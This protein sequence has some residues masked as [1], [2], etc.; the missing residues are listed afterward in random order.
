MSH[1]SPLPGS[2]SWGPATQVWGSE[3]WRWRVSRWIDEALSQRGVTR[4]PTSP[5]Q[6]RLRPWSTQLVVE[7]DRG[8]AWFK[9]TLPEG[10]PEVA[11]LRLLSEVAPDL[12]P[13]LW[14]AAPERGWFIGPDQGRV[15]R[16]VATPETITRLWS[17]VLRRY[18]RLQRASVTV[19][20]QLVAAGAPRQTP[21]DLAAAW[22]CRPAS[23]QR[24]LEALCAAAAG[25]TRSVYL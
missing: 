18:A 12:I 7:T 21:R 19:T 23:S 13:P 24:G 8:R 4:V 10:T 9:A 6:P 22:G 5:R 15:L 2:D 20:E 3:D 1:R 25:W 11:V 16:T 17:G 14:A